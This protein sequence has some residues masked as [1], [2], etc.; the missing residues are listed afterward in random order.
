MEGV[1]DSAIRIVMLCTEGADLT[2]TFLSACSLTGPCRAALLTSNSSTA[3][4]HWINHRVT[5]IPGCHTPV[6]QLEV[7]SFDRDIRARRPSTALQACNWVCGRGTSDVLQYHV[8]DVKV[9]GVAVPGGARE[10]C[11]L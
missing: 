4:A 3:E 6:S 7:D 8:F 2:F 1:L 11:A 5:I 10:G 9:R